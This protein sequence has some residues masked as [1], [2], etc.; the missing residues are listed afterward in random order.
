M[1]ALTRHRAE[2]SHQETWHIY[3]TDVHVGT[4]NRCSGV[5]THS[6][7]WT[8]SIGFYPG[9]QRGASTTTF[10]DARGTFDR[11]WQQLAPKLN[12]ENYEEW[13][14]NRDFHA[15]K[16]RM[17]NEGCRMPTQNQ[18]GWSTCFCGACIPIACEEHINTV[19]RGIGA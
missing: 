9:M 1:T 13:R 3:F 19:H 7:Q 10:E 5:P 16:R 17:W 6:D 4:I 11:A 15:W 14:R 12:E 18:D 8:W 2:N